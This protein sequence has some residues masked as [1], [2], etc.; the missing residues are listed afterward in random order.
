MTETRKGSSAFSIFAFILFAVGV[1]VFAVRLVHSGPYAMPHGGPLYAALGSML[2]GGVLVWGKHRV[3]SWGAVLLSPL[4]LFPAIYSI[5]GESEE[6][7]SLYATDSNENSVDLRL[8]IVD[9][10]DGSWVGMSMRKAVEHDL[11]GAQLRMLRA[12]ENVCVTPVLHEDRP[13]VQA[14]HRMK[15]EKYTVAKL[16]G[17]MGSYPLEAPDTTIAL[18]LDPCA[19]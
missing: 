7:I 12:G 17:A 11:D 5:A 13:T 18:R 8:W 6:V 10:D 16:A 15:V 14:V 3:L 1:A 9:R 2:L 4:A 19:G